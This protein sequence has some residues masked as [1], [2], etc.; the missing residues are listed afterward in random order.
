M[1]DIHI[2]GWLE[3]IRQRYENYLKTLFFFKE[4]LLRESFQ[5]ALREQGSLMK[6]PFQERNRGFARGLPASTLAAECFTNGAVDLLPA[7]IDGRLYTHLQRRD[8][9]PMITHPN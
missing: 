1:A 3:R 2:Q 9:L 6:G 5:E 4:P 8:I 7:L